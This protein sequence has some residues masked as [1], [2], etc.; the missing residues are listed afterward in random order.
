MTAVRSASPVPSR[1]R[2]C[3]GAQATI[4]M[5]PPQPGQDRPD[6]HSTVPHCA[7][8]LAASPS[9]RCHSGAEPSRECG[10]QEPEAR[11]G[12]P[13]EACNVT[14]GAGQ[15]VRTPV[16]RLNLVPLTLAEANAFVAAH[17][18]HHKPVPGAK[19]SIGV[20]MDDR[21]VGVAIVGRPVARM[22]QDGLTLE[23]NRVATD[24]TRNACSFLYG[25]SWRAAKALGYRRLITYTLNTEPGASLRGAGWRLVG[26]AGGGPWSRP[27]RPSVD[28]HPLQR[29][30]RW[31][32]A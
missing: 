10:R 7:D 29:K 1:E 11:E 19:F 22:L 18:R 30:L 23:V 24:G 32:A 16:C 31:E 17:H 8:G 5:E 20:A 3:R 14:A 28:T 6:T 21:V 2:G 15:G 12:T 13:L 26:E 27:S 4:R 25:A 9:L